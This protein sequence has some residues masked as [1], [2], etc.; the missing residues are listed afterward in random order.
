MSPSAGEWQAAGKLQVGYPALPALQASLL[1]QTICIGPSAPHQ[2]FPDC[3][4]KHSLLIY[5]LFASHMH[6]LWLTSTWC[7]HSWVFTVE[8]IYCYTSAC[9]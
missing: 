7:L 9:R 6:D 2:L 8:G 3:L 1:C 4:I 5:G